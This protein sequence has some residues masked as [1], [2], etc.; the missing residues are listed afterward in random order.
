M[1]WP[2]FCSLLSGVMPETPLGQ[3]VSIRSEKDPKVIKNF[4][5]QQKKIRSDW[6]KRKYKK[7]KNNTGAYAQ[8]WEGFRSWAQSNFSKK[9][10]G[11]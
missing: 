4:N 8:Y 10:E 1:P 5:P 7:L 6:A 3:I 11:I 9:G 2:E